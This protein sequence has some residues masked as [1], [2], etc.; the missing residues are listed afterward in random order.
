MRRLR[1]TLI[2]LCASLAVFSAEIT[3]QQALEKA[4]AFMQQRKGVATKM[5]RAPLNI[6]MQQTETGLQTLYAFNVEGG[7]YVIASGDD[8]TLPELDGI[9]ASVE[10]EGDIRIIIGASYGKFYDDKT[11]MDI[12]VKMGTIATPGGVTAIDDIMTMDDVT[13]DNGIYDLYGRRVSGQPR[14]G[15][16]IKNKKKIHYSY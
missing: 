15:I 2:L 13:I 16:Y 14:K 9:F 10:N 1:I 4:R 11:L 12:T 7:G 3:P 5:R 6:T 8:R